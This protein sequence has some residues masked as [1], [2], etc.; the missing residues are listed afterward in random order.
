MDANLRQDSKKLGFSH[1]RS[2]KRY[3]YTRKLQFTFFI[4]LAVVCV[5]ILICTFWKSHNNDGGTVF[6][7]KNWVEY[8]I[9]SES[10]KTAQEKERDRQMVEYV[11][12]T[13]SLTNMLH[14]QK[15]HRLPDLIGIGVEK[16]GTTALKYLMKMHPMI[17]SSPKEPHFFNSFK[18]RKG[19][20][21]YKS[22]LAEV[23]P[24]EL[25]SEKTPAYFNWG[26]SIP[27][28]IRK[29]VP[30]AKLFLVLCDPVNRTYSDYA[31]EIMMKNLNKDK[32][33]KEFASELLA[34]YSTDLMKNMD[35]DSEQIDF[36]ETSMKKN[37]RSHVL[38]TGLY[39]Y[40]LLR[41]FRVYNASEI[42]IIDGE[43][44]ISNPAKIIKEVQQFL[45]IPEF[46]LSENIILDKSGFYCFAKPLVVEQDGVL[47]AATSKTECMTGKG[48]TRKGAWGL[49]DPESM[50][51]LRKFFDPFN[52]KL[53]K[54]LG[55]KFNW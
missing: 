29:F 4:F 14:L 12:A 53:Y 6:D 22:L 44:L 51:K 2:K 55:R 27:Q 41:W 36:I 7:G 24:H 37:M 43:E 16:C 1:M 32:P 54:L 20:E 42:L 48:R 33:F 21:V 3:Y 8:R 40:H 30:N 45:K 31:Q 34:G 25:S 28:N 9:K 13:R 19:V 26:V 35:E 18:Y 17:K 38:T 10:E 50:E 39:Y 49:P 5:F 47:V 52:Q 11:A 46:I 23:L 15:I